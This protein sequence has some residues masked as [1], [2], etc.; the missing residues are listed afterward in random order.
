[1]NRILKK[2]ENPTAWVRSTWSTQ[3]ARNKPKIREKSIPTLPNK[4]QPVSGTSGS[5]IYIYT[6]S[7]AH[8]FPVVAFACISESFPTRHLSGNLPSER[9][10][11]G[12]KSPYNPLPTLSQIPQIYNISTIRGKQDTAKG[13]FSPTGE[14]GK[15]GLLFCVGISSLRMYCK[16]ERDND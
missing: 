8:S 1:M 15:Q 2:K 4:T 11:F 14:G 9:N 6:P 3:E 5:Y 7:F 13:R 16:I 12:T 10:P